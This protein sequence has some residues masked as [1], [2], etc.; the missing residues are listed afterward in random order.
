[1]SN[2][3]LPSIVPN[4][5]KYSRNCTS[6]KFGSRP[7]INTLRLLFDTEFDDEDV[8]DKWSLFMPI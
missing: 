8:D 3:F 6:G 7:P 2:F 5:E 4:C 1:M